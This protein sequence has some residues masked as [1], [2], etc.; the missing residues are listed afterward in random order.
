MNRVVK[1]I[2]NVGKD[3]DPIKENH[4]NV[5]VCA[6]DYFGCCVLYFFEYFVMITLILIF[7]IIGIVYL[8]IIYLR[9]FSA[10]VMFG[11]L[12]CDGMFFF[13]FFPNL[14]FRANRRKIKCKSL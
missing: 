2:Q 4:A 7:G 6:C 14:S 10:W 3:I 1:D 8:L 9:Q 5:C 12:V 11:A 13:D